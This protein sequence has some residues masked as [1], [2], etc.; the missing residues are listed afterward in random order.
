MNLALRKYDLHAVFT[1]KRDFIMP[2]YFKGNWAFD[3]I[4]SIF[5]NAISIVI[6][7]VENYVCN[8]LIKGN[9]LRTI[10]VITK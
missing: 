2:L 1:K 7:G 4:L 8:R 5:F 9:N 3:I 10:V 6:A